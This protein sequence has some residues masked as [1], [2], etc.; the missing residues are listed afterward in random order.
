MRLTLRTLL[1][2]L[3]DQLDPADAEVLAKKIAASEFATKQV[4]RI[5]D[6]TRRLRLGAPKLRGRG[7][8]L[9]PNT[10]AEY[11][12]NTLSNQRVP[13][14][15]KLS[16]ESDIYLAEVAACHQILARIL[17][18]P[19]EIDPASRER[20]YELGHEPGAHDKQAA[21]AV[22]KDEAEPV[23]DDSNKVAADEPPLRRRPEIPEYLRDETS[24]RGRVI[25]AS[26]AVLLVVGFTVVVWMALRP[27][28]GEG[29]LVVRDDQTNPSGARETSDQGPSA[30]P[31]A[32]SPDNPS[33]GPS[34]GA[35]DQPPAPAPIKPD[36]T[37]SD[38]PRSTP[39]P[40]PSDR[41][42][43]QDDGLITPPG[44][45]TSTSKP[46]MPATDLAEPPS[47]E[48]A[49]KPSAA[50]AED[51]PPAESTTEDEP[52]PPQQVGKLDGRDDL[53]VRFD[54]GEDT[55][56][57]VPEQDPLFSGDVLVG[58]PT[59]PAS[60]TLSTGVRVRPIGGARIVLV[61][62]D[63]AGIPGVNIDYGQVLFEP[64][65]DQAPAK[66]RLITGDRRGTLTLE[67]PGSRVAVEVVPYRTPG[68]NP[69]EAAPRLIIDL[70]TVSGRV[71]WMDAVSEMPEPFEA[72]A[73]K[74]LQGPALPAAD[75]QAEGDAPLPA[76]TR[77]QEPPSPLDLRA[78]GTVKQHLE[79]GKPV[80][81]SL[82]ELV[83]DRRSE[84]RSLAARCLAYLDEFEAL[85]DALND[86]AH[87][88][89]NAWF[90]HVNTLYEALN[91]GPEI[92]NRFHAALLRQRPP[93]ADQIER[94][95][96]GY[97]PEQIKAGAGKQLLDDLD[98]DDLAVRSLAFWNLRNLTG[99]I[100]YYRPHDKASARQQAIQN[101]RKR[102]PEWLATVPTAGG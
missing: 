19:A 5:R 56:M 89:D 72:P 74:R 38:T 63:E 31:G 76:W 80:T 101:W 91:R 98:S 9:D 47:P 90:A 44:D 36:S 30:Q 102:L 70:Y 17:T 3:D 83:D 92:A 96:W 99:L 88:S 60:V 84:I 62:P 23:H 1:A 12:E 39:A 40:A 49:T 69:E 11:L 52:A 34:S 8:G 66:V 85:I 25:A 82:E 78:A 33:S 64:V 67:T 6:V 94:M 37:S 16:L 86:P 7:M 26:I 41:A 35:N 51:E 65:A 13:D 87:R 18:D 73:E 43:G 10:V 14:F 50:A 53:L 22:A 48:E 55:W 32:G 24:W 45:E 77:G 59:L 71:S 15:E 29:P 46:A 54:K 57:L 27:P 68:T 93:G 28:G 97:T 61:A 75:L 95:L 2:Y 79:V 20:M 21:D 58:L 4:T 42:K 100:L 81:V